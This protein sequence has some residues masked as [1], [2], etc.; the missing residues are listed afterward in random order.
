M[1]NK[2]TKIPNPHDQF[3]RTVMSDNRVACDFLKAWLPEDLRERI[4]F[5]ALTM[6]P[7][8]YISDVRQESEVDVLFKTLIDNKE[9]YVYF[10]L[11]HQSKPD[12]LMAFRMLKYVCHIMEDH[13]NSNDIKR[14]PLI[15]P[16][17]IYHGPR[18]YPYSTDIRDLIDAPRDLV[19]RYCLTP[20]HLIDL[21][22]I[23]D[24]AIKSH[25][26]SGVVEFALKHIFSRDMLPWLKEVTELMH[27]LASQDGRDLISIVLQYMLERGEV[28]D[29]D[30]FFNLIDTQVSP[31]VGETI[32]SLAVQLREEGRLEGQYLVAKRLLEEGAD[33]AFVVKV[34]GLT[35]EQLTQLQTHS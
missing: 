24:E 4:D 3:F 19:E 31:E 12:P 7:R 11:E 33:T 35:L 34:T 21:G 22:Q 18:R 20:F 16:M 25:A 17:V 10:L 8:S 32:M 15:Y 2:K 27:H 26:W 28:S 9:G 30:E 23:S 6:Q 1:K 13:L 5:T 29:R 14:L